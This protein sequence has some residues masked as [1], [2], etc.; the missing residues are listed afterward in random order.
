MLALLKAKGDDPVFAPLLAIGVTEV[1]HFLQGAGSSNFLA[2]SVAGPRGSTMVTDTMELIALSIA[3]I[4]S[5]RRPSP[6][7][8]QSH[9]PEFSGRIQG[10]AV[11]ESVVRQPTLRPLA[12]VRQSR[13]C[14]AAPV[15]EEHDHYAF[16]FGLRLRDGL[17]PC[18]EDAFGVAELGIFAPHVSKQASGL[19]IDE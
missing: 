17:Y 15:P 7:L 12:Y 5:F 1:T 6:G 3:R 10:T 2:A 9:A 18:L 19:R 8:I 4:V 13:G 16:D 11:H 14:D